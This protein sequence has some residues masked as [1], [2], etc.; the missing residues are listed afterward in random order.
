MFYRIDQARVCCGHSFKTA[1]P[2][3]LRDS[4]TIRQVKKDLLANRR[5]DSCKI[6]WQA[7][8]RGMTSLR[9]LYMGHFDKINREDFTETSQHDLEYLELRIDNLC[10][11]ACRICDADSSTL[12]SGELEEHP[13]LKPWLGIKID[14]KVPVSRQ[15]TEDNWQQILDRI[16][17]LK[18]LQLTGGEPMLIKKFYDVMDLLI[19]KGI[20][21]R[22]TLMITTNCSVVNPQI[23][24]RLSKFKTVYIVASIDGVEKT[25]EYQ[26]H[27]TNWP[28]VK[29]NV[30]TFCA[31]PN[32]YVTFNG[33]LTAYNVLDFAN[34]C[35][36]FADMC[37][38]NER[39]NFTFNMVAS[40][41][42]MH[43]TVLDGVL[44]DR[45]I[46]QL[47]Q[48]LDI[49][50]ART[51]KKALIRQI[52]GMIH[53]MLTVDNRQDFGRFVDYTRDYDQARGESFEQVFGHKLY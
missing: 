7:E 4:E 45:A 48:G 32:C 16:S 43:P 15:I 2:A 9:N 28:V 11:F 19:E 1:T 21:E 17:S 35:S 44:R 26:R 31:L 47:N 46:A 30:Q 49:V 5:P 34:L 53:T 8:D 18:S 41:D 14:Q 6:C 36:Y 52:E 20:A 3:D 22:L 50:V 25:A 51:S 23:L 37:D 33:T 10:N 24:Q 42:H 12:L 27:G 39:V 40:R 38:V 13:Q 29:K